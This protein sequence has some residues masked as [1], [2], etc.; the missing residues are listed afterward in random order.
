M[1]GE[2]GFPLESVFLWHR[3]WWSGD[4]GVKCTEGEKGR[5]QQEDGIPE[6]LQAALPLLYVFKPKQ[7][8]LSDLSCSLLHPQA[9]NPNQVLPKIIETRK[10][11]NFQFLKFKLN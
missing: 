11:E 1:C 3:A 6:C 2:N 4:K 10:H 5:E 7:V 8:L 9:P